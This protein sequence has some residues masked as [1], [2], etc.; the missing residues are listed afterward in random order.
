[1]SHH[2]CTVSSV[3]WLRHVDV[4]GG[5]DDIV[6]ADVCVM[7]VALRQGRGA[8]EAR[9]TRTFNS[10]S[11][12]WWVTVKLREDSDVARIAVPVSH[13][14]MRSCKGR[15]LSMVDFMVPWIFCCCRS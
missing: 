11:N 6:R 10:I 7:D 2:D 3:S 8:E 4:E 9:H 15:T 5:N 14:W 12:N 13:E 1:M